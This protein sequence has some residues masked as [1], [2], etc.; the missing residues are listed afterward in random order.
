MAWLDWALVA[1][2]FVAALMQ[3]KEGLFR[4][5]KAFVATG[6]RRASTARP[7]LPALFFFREQ[8]QPSGQMRLAVTRAGSWPTAR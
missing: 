4:G 5:A 7:A 8:L 1:M 2:G 3:V 6:S